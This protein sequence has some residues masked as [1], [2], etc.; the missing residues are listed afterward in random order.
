[1]YRVAPVRNKVWDLRIPKWQSKKHSAVAQQ[2]KKFYFCRRVQPQTSSLISEHTKWE[3]HLDY[4]P[5]AGLPLMRLGHTWVHD[6][7]W[8][9]I[10]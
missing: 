4:I 9:A 6:S 10:V 2:G 3:V 7:S 1:M 5:N 8:L